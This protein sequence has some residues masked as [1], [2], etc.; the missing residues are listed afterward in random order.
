MKG[1][2]TME[3]YFT[4]KTYENMKRIGEPF[5]NEKGRL[6]TKV[7]GTCERCGGLGYI[8]SG[9]LNGRPVPISRDGGVCYECNG[10]KYVIKEVRLYT[11]KEF[12]S[13]FAIS[14]IVFLKV[15]KNQII[16]QKRHSLIEIEKY[17]GFILEI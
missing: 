8:A 10:D 4:A 11:E 1:M 6:F 9:V 13:L 17:K 12:N 3:K 7:K 15:Q 14:Y 5:V 2:V 16:K